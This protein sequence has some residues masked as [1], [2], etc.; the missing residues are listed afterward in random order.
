MSE[1]GVE[2]REEGARLWLTLANRDRKNAISAAMWRALI[3]VAG[4]LAQRTDLRVVILRGAGGAFSAGADITGFDQSR[5]DATTAADYD[6]LV[7][8]ACR[9]LAAIPMPSLAVIEGP[10][11]GAGMSLASSC[12]LRL[13]EADAY[14]ALPAARLGLG[15]DP[16]G[17][18][19]LVDV[20]GEGAARQ[21]LMTGDHMPATRA[22]QLGAVQF[23]AERD[24]L[25]RSI[26]AIASRLEDNAPLTLKAA[27]LTLASLAAGAPEGLRKEVECARQAADT[28]ADYHE[29]RRAFAEKRPPRF[30]GS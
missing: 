15:Y 25:D 8:T 23:F 10:C 16:R 6:D 21:L 11:I 2:L 19:R 1:G 24:Q 29:G 9:A 3:E 4:T 26:E 28:S 14:F 20:F 12:D 27:K 18:E 30:T 13:A 17:I 5:T 22:Y 7:E